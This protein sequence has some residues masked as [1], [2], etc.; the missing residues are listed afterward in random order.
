MLLHMNHTEEKP[1]VVYEQ[2]DSYCVWTKRGRRPTFFHPTKELAEAEAE[3]LAIKHPGQKFIVM[4]M[5]GKFSTEQEATDA[6]P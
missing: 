6:Q 1:R 2:K 5:M 4:Q 3:R